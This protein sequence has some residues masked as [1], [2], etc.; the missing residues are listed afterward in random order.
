M[1][2]HPAGPVVQIHKQ[3]ITSA[4]CKLTQIVDPTQA[5]MSLLSD[6]RSSLMSVYFLSRFTDRSD[7][8]M[9]SKCDG[10]HLAATVE[11]SRFSF[12]ETVAIDF[13]NH[14]RLT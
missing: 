4:E 11:P 12:S 8:R 14:R 9:R 10:A 2:Q 1:H 3:T 13:H 6:D 5:L 7:H